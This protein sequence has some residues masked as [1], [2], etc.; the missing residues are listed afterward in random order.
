MIISMG[1]SYCAH[2][3]I[4]DK[5][6]IRSAMKIDQETTNESSLS[7]FSTDK[8]LPSATMK[9]KGERKLMIAVKTNLLYDLALTPNLELELPIGRHWSINVEYQYGWWFATTIASAGK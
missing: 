7:L 2:A 5:A 3:Q 8:L 4:N 6:L 9:Q 1:Y